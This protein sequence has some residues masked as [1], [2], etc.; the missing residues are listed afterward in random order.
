MSVDLSDL[1][2][3]LTTGPEIG[4]VG[5]TCAKEPQAVVV[6]KI[7]EDRAEGL[8]CGD[9]VVGFAGYRCKSAIDLALILSECEA[10]QRVELV[11]LSSPG[12]RRLTVDLTLGPL[13]RLV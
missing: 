10:G 2:P 5:H 7:T 9:R 4:F 6:K 8:R 11:V 12:G 3:C 13:R 1:S